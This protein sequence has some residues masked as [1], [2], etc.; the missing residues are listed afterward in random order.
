MILYISAC[1]PSVPSRPPIGGD[2]G[3]LDTDRPVPFSPQDRGTTVSP[4]QRT[5]QVLQSPPNHSSPHVGG[6]TA[7][8]LVSM[9]AGLRSGIRTY[10]EVVSSH[11]GRYRAS[12]K[13]RNI[14][15]MDR[16]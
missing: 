5:S 14:P 2:R 10:G 7:S 15:R 1:R 16:S 9:I 11:A 12:P 6:L 3:G 8:P 4:G 13:V